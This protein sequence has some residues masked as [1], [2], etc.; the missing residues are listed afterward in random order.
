MADRDTELLNDLLK[1]GED[2]LIT[3]AT[4]FKGGGDVSSRDFRRMAML[5]A[6]DAVIERAKEGKQ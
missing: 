1:A 3:M 4:A 2:Y 5:K 6:L